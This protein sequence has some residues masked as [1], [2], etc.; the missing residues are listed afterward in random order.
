MQKDLPQ[1]LRKAFKDDKDKQ[2]A[3]APPRALEGASAHG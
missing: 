1:H 2:V 3:G